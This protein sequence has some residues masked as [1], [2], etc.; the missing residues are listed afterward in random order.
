MA[1][2]RHHTSASSAQPQSVTATSSHP[3]DSDRQVH[4]TRDA[5]L[6][7]AVTTPPAVKRPTTIAS[8]HS[9]GSSL[10]NGSA[11]SVAGMETTH[12]ITRSSHGRLSIETRAV[13]FRRPSLA[14]ASVP[15]AQSFAT[16]ASSSAVR[17]PLPSTRRE[18]LSDAKRIKPVAFYIPCTDKPDILPFPS[19]GSQNKRARSPSLESAC[20]RVPA[21]FPR[22]SS[23]NCHPHELLLALTARQKRADMRRSH[24]LQERRLRLRRR[25]EQI[26]YHILLQRQLTEIVEG[27]LTGV[28]SESNTDSNNGGESGEADDLNIFALHTD[29]YGE[30]LSATVRR[31][32]V[33]PV[34]LLEDME[35][36]AYLEL[37]ELLPPITRFTLRELELSEILSNAQLRHDLF[38]DPELQFKPNLDGEK[39]RQKREAADAY[40]EEVDSEVNAGHLYRLPLLL[41]EMRVIIIELLP[42]SA[43]RKED[44]ERHIDVRLIAQQM[45]HGVLDAL[46]LV[47]YIA[48]LLKANCAPARDCLVD[49]MVAEC[50]GGNFVK[51]LRQCFEVLEFMKLVGIGG[52][53][54]TRSC[55]DQ[56]MLPYRI[57]PIMSCTEFDRMWWNMRQ[58][59]SGGGSRSSIRP[60]FYE[61]TILLCGLHRH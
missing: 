8:P 53:T 33:L 46:A 61:S 41:F 44:V 48:D 56:R 27:N 49:A 31:L 6:A 35:E 55:T 28:S 5:V 25:A 40:W 45:Q 52:C 47:Q 58:I 14:S 18:S 7:A 29:V 2:H 34:A 60:A 17:S 3:Q 37:L 16:R 36:S 4:A 39:G 57:M 26:R 30:S 9:Q 12:F 59:M 24:L 22:I 11:A 54:C 1:E 32:R 15:S 50:Q 20:L 42:Y 38:F 21:S 51:T 10:S 19:P 23:P 13:S 43:E